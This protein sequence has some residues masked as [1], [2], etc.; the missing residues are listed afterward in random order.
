M[1]P[2]ANKND[3]KGMGMEGFFS[4]EEKARF[5]SIKERARKLGVLGISFSH[6][7][8]SDAECYES[9]LNIIEEEK[10]ILDKNA[11]EFDGT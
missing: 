3:H 9:V 7:S 6:A 1:N 10:D 8:A 2:K 11:G 4:E 5:E